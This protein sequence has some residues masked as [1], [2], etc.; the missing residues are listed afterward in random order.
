[1]KRGGFFCH[2]RLEHKH[3]PVMTLSFSFD[4]LAGDLTLMAARGQDNSCRCH[5][6]PPWSHQ[7]L[8]Q[9]HVGFWATKLHNKAEAHDPGQTPPL[10]CLLRTVRVLLAR[11]ELSPRLWKED[12]RSEETDNKEVSLRFSRTKKLEDVAEAQMEGSGKKGKTW[13]QQFL[14][15]PLCA[16][17]WPINSDSDED[18][19]RT[20]KL[21][22]SPI[23]RWLCG[24]QEARTSSGVSQ[25]GGKRIK[26]NRN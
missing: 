20:T 5:V 19:S 26:Y 9:S 7:V 13:K 11:R 2:R 25:W 16:C 8:N 1:M 18:G 14:K 4:W 3:K 10:T 6:T 22:I 24:E 21:C 12:S 17:L 23:M 15:R